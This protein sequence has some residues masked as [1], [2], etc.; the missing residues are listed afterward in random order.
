VEK[1]RTCLSLFGD[2]GAGYRYNLEV[3]VLK[4]IED[5]TTNFTTVTLCSKREK[6]KIE[7]TWRF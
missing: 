1:R 3:P 5:K 2:T 4:K 7:I 6:T